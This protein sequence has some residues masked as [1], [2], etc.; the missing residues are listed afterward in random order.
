MKA[1]TPVEAIAL[2]VE[3]VSGK[4]LPRVDAVGYRVVHPGPKL[5]RHVRINDAVMKDLEE[6]VVFAPLHDPAVIEVIKD[7]MQRFPDVQ[8]YACFD[9]VFHETMSEAATTYP[10]PLKYREA[11]RAAVWISWVEL[12][13]DCGAAACGEG[14]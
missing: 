1:E 8:H 12:R 10:I 13:V 3:A 4:G 5:D 6:A 11:G 14:D 7:I 2:V 9:T